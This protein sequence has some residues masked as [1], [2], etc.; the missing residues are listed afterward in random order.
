[1]GGVM[2]SIVVPS[3]TLDTLATR[4]PLPDVLKIDVEGAELEVLSASGTVLRQA[5]PVILCEVSE[6]ASDG[7]TA[8]LRSAG[9]RLFDG[10]A[11]EPLARELSRATWNTIALPP[12]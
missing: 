9:Y 5:R 10:E 3:A 1:M 4:F 12:T 11:A 8:I 7:A 2:D 6:A